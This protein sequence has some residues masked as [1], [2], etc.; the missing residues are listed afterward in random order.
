MITKEKIDCQ[1]ER[2]IRHRL[3]EN[4][5]NTH[6]LCPDSS[7]YLV[8]F[9]YCIPD[10]FLLPFKNDGKYLIPLCKKSPFTFLLTFAP[11]VSFADTFPDKRGQLTI[12]H[13]CLSYIGGFPSSGDGFK[14]T[15][16]PL[17]PNK[18][19]R[20]FYINHFYIFVFIYIKIM[21]PFFLSIS[22]PRTRREVPSFAR[23]QGQV[24]VHRLEHHRKQNSPLPS[25][26]SGGQNRNDN[27]RKNRLSEGAKNPA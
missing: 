13:S 21:I 1:R 5:C 7:L 22:F 10:R 19:K 23:R 27:K 25:F 16:F 8:L 18:Q 15:F 11:F 6:I 24:G 14:V 4:A 12:L 9:Y 2:R 26:L 3:S 17:F 20:L